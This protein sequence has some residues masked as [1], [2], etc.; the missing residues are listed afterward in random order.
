M[1]TVGE[2]TELCDFF[3]FFPDAGHGCQLGKLSTTELHPDS[4]QINCTMCELNLNKAVARDKA[5]PRITQPEKPW[6][7]ALGSLLVRETVEKTSL[8]P[9]WELGPLDLPTTVSQALVVCWAVQWQPATG[10]HWGMRGEEPLWLPR[11]CRGWGGC[12]TSQVIVAGGCGQHAELPV[13]REGH[14]HT[15]TRVEEAA[16][17]GGGGGPPQEPRKEQAFPGLF[18]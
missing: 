17:A 13:R 14:T 8:L 11:R 5:V 10:G 12:P 15:A 4:K 6:S 1:V 9:R 16:A 3:F 7:Q 18:T 2:S